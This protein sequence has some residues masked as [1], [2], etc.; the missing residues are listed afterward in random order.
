LVKVLEVLVGGFSEGCCGAVYVVESE[1]VRSGIPG[2]DEILN[3][4]FPRGRVILVMGSPGAGKTVFCTQ[5]LVRGAESFG[6]RGVLALL[7]ESRP[8]VLREMSR[9]GWDLEALER[10][11]KICVLD[12]RPARREKFSVGVERRGL[13]MVSEVVGAASRIGAKRIVVD[14]LSSL[15]FQFPRP[16][17]RRLVVLDLIDR[18]LETGATSLLTLEMGEADG[19]REVAVEEFL[20]HGVIALSSVRVANSYVKT[21]RVVKMR[22]TL[23]DMQVRPFA[24]TGEGIQIYPKESVF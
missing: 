17:E 6:E 24:I 19:G 14:S 18:L 20:A 5:F 15:I 9:F 16:E 12:A 1:R 4:G 8:Y 11:G 10:E 13:S 7:E 2:L 21:L 23:H 3:G 22:E